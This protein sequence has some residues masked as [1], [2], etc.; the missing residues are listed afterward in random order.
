M[1]YS[2]DSNDADVTVNVADSVLFAADNIAAA[3][4]VLCHLFINVC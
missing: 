3:W 4:L 2:V 1:A